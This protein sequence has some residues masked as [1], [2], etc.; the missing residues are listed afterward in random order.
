MPYGIDWWPAQD[1]NEVGNTA[2]D[3][4]MG[5]ALAEQSIFEDTYEDPPSQLAKA[6]KERNKLKKKDST[7]GIVP[8]YKT[9]PRVIKNSTQESIFR[10]RSVQETSTRI[11]V[12]GTGNIGR[13]VAHALAGIGDSS[14]ITL[15]SNRKDIIQQWDEEGRILELIVGNA[16]CPRSG[17]DVSH[18][19]MLGSRTDESEH[20]ID[21]L[22]VT[23]EASATV[24]ILLAIKERLLPS[25]TICF[26][27]N[28]MGIME[29]VNTIVF[30]NP[31]TRPRYMV[32]ITSHII[33]GQFGRAFTTIQTR[34]GTIYL[35]LV[36]QT[37]SLPNKKNITGERQI[38]E[39]PLVQRM[40][41]GWTASS[42]KLMRSL[43]QCMILNARGFRYEEMLQLQFERLA[44]NSVLGPLSVLFDCAHGKLFKNSAVTEL[45]RGL[46]E[47]IV[48]VAHSVPE[49][50]KLDHFKDHFTS[51]RLECLIVQIASR[52]NNTLG[53]MLEDVRNG[54]LTDIN[55]IN[56][57]IVKRGQ[58]L[59]IPCPV[60]TTVIQ[61]VEAKHAM[62]MS[63]RASF[64]PFK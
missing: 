12:L 44:V 2:V 13:F 7:I 48:A 57:Y 45:M 56:G 47:E 39:K 1:K 58:E 43:S 28:G 38:D 21:K 24:S 34:P 25:S 60:N 16:S 19:A 23:V 33:R 37:L 54:R 53:S 51:K 18:V 3:H 26:L 11:H 55:F 32:G 31:A 8:I 22:I 46:L 42:R 14:P 4:M 27:Q 61:M 40:Y 49:L 41:Y 10:R 50:R 63:K 15:L 9:L 35:S 36:P 20:I 29:D 62:T 6:A 5:Q 52:S 30:P 17:I 64:I 59:R